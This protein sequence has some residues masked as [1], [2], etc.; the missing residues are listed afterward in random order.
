MVFMKSTPRTY[1]AAGLLFA[2]GSLAAGLV[3]CAQVDAAAAWQTQ[4]AKTEGSAQ[5]TATVEPRAV[6]ATAR[7]PVCGMYP[8]RY[9][10][11]AAQLHFAGGQVHYF[12]SPVEFL[13]FQR[14]IARYGK[15]LRTGDI[16][17]GY[18]T[19][20]SGG[21]WVAAVDATYVRGSRVRGPM[22]EDAFPAFATRDAAAALV[23]A[24]GGELLSYAELVA[25][26]SAAKRGGSG[27]HH[28]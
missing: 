10:Q 24:Q 14:D 15:G 7:C 3:H 5:A 16:V 19:D 17:A 1:F 9:G 27:H 26:F 2:A 6:P 25:A 20:Y 22:G 13:T 4:L 8:A 28:H 21:G 12:D 11:W 23:A 18:V